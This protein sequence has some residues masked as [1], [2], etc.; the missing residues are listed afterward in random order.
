[1]FG[2]R[3]E[4]NFY[5]TVKPSTRPGDASIGVSPGLDGGF[6]FIVRL[7]FQLRALFKTAMHGYKS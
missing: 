2:E 1:M 4:G 7:S 3:T 5:F 6:Y